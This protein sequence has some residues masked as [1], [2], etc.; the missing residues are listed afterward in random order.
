M[1]QCA[2][3]GI[4]NIPAVHTRMARYQDNIAR[5]MVQAISVGVTLFISVPALGSG[6]W[7]KPTSAS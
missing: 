6:I 2:F 7:L 1:V 5:I 3:S 4:G